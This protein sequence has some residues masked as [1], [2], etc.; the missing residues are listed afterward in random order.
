MMFYA[1]YFSSVELHAWML[2]P[3][4]APGK[5]PR[6]GFLKSFQSA[7]EFSSNPDQTHIPVIF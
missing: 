1:N 4:P 3:V 5:H 7:A 6:P 2:E